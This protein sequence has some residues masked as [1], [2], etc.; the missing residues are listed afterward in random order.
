MLW[1]QLYICKVVKG[2]EVSRMKAPP[3]EVVQCVESDPTS[4]NFWDLAAIQSCTN[5]HSCYYVCTLYLDD[6]NPGF[7]I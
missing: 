3:W 2:L 1:A 6:I 4:R 5:W 7:E